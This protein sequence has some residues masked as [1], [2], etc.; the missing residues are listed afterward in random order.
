MEERA[1]W[2]RIGSAYQEE[3]FDV[4]RS[5]RLKV[6]PKII[7]KYAN[8]DHTAIDFGCGTGRAFEYLSPSFK[9]VFGVDISDNLLAIAK[10][11][12]FSNITFKQHDL[13]K[14]L[15]ALAD[16]GFCC[17]VV[18]L[19]EIHLNKLMLRNIRQSIKAGGNVVI[20]MPSLESF[21]YSGWRLIDWC[22]KENE[23]IDHSDLAGFRGPKADLIEGIVRIDNVKTKHYLETELILLFTETGF[24]HIKITKVEYDW[25]SEFSSPPAWMKEPYPWD[26]IIEA[27]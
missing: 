22:R 3:I 7:A 5:D 8:K 23:E 12:S 16:F 11:T 20:V 13:T 1:H 15:K 10:K 18:M 26:W 21:M 17:N 14:P 24:R 25:T 19:P 4:F 2:N 6:I 27:S 9:S